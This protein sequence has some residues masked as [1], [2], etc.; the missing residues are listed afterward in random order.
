MNYIITVIPN[1]SLGKLLKICR[2]LKHTVS[3]SA[4]CKGTAEKSMLD[5]LGIEDN[6]KRLVMTIADNENTKKL[7]KELKH[8]I[9]IGF[10]GRGVAI[11]VP[12]KSVGGGKTVA[13]LNSDNTL[14]KKTPEINYSYELIVVI[15]NEGYTDT[16]MKAARASG[17]RG[18]TVIHGKGT[19]SKETQKFYNLSIASE[20]EVIL[21]L[22]ASEQKAE[23]MK[24]ILKDA[25][26]DSKAGSV[27]FSLPVNNIAGFGT[28][29][30]ND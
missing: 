18:G 24:S 10:P 9:Q 28:F 6:E 25:G 8:K 3:L 11:S 13:Y 27:I 15:S 19:G 2:D 26:P 22:S 5:L 12:V 17:A 1:D 4:L 14:E 7:F 21:I 20:K 29:D 16:V 30:E 23:I